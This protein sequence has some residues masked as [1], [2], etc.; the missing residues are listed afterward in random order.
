MSD[1]TIPKEASMRNRRSHTQKANHNDPLFKLLILKTSGN[2]WIFD[3]QK[4]S[5]CRNLTCVTW[6][7]LFWE[8]KI[9]NDLGWHSWASTYFWEWTPKKEILLKSMDRSCSRLLLKSTTRLPIFD[10]GN[11]STKIYFS[12]KNIQKRFRLRLP[13]RWF[14]QWDILNAF[15]FPFP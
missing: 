6:A 14:F 4:S 10:V 9:W 15:N 3:L 12:Q 5:K 8:H 11:D 7:T 2:L 13:L 1:A